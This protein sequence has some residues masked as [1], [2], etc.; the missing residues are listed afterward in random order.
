MTR[1][2]LR[3]NIIIVLLCLRSREE[4]NQGISYCC[5][6]EVT[7]QISHCWWTGS[8]SKKYQLHH[9]LKEEQKWRFRTQMLESLAI[10]STSKFLQRALRK[11]MHSSTELFCCMN[12]IQV[13]I[14]SFMDKKIRPTPSILI[15][16]EECFYWP[17][18]NSSVRQKCLFRSTTQLVSCCYDSLILAIKGWN[19]RNH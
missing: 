4:V 7:P 13:T 9:K 17:M 10:C 6:C 12:T 3:E 2:S 8:I 18:L 11:R 16:L 5:R 19:K 14:S 1:L 15:I